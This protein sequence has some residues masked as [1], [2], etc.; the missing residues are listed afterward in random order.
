[1]SSLGFHVC[2]VLKKRKR[3]VWVFL[4]II[5]LVDTDILIYLMITNLV[6]HK[7]NYLHLIAE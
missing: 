6:G 4:L 2:L 1:M 7:Y 5:M 3:V